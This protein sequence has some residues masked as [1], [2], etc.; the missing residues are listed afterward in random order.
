MLKILELF[1]VHCTYN[2]INK[3]NK[4]QMRNHNNGIKLADAFYYT[5]MYSKQGTTKDNIV[6]TIN[7]KN[8][9]YFSRQAY[10]SKAN[11]IPLEIYL[12]LLTQIRNHYNFNYVDI[13]TPKLI[14]IDGTYNNNVLMEEILNM[15]FYDI[16]NGVP[17]DIKSYGKE[18]KN[19][20]V[21]CAT[22]YIKSN[23]DIFKNN[24]IVADRAYYSYE[25]MDF[26]IKNNI[27][28]II[29]V[30][31]DAPLLTSTK[32]IHKS[33]EHYNE[34]INV[35]NN[36]RVIKYKNIINKTV[37]SGIS[38]KKKNTEYTLEMNNDCVIITNLL[39]ENVYNDE[40]LMD[41]YRQ[42]WSI[43]IFFKYIKS[44]F[45][46]R[47]I[48]EKSKKKIN[49]MYTC[50]LIIM[51][52][53]KIIEETY[54]KTYPIKNKMGYTHN[55]NLTN[56][57]T[58]IHN[59]LLYKLLNNTLTE[60]TLTRFIKCYVKIIIN[61]VDRSF[62]RTSKTPF[63]KWYIKGYSSLSYYAR[64]ISHIINNTTDKLHKNLKTVAKRIISINGK[65]Y[66]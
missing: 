23:T 27:K 9:T 25:F 57:V 53:A 17:I 56:L 37:Y 33:N 65:K 34:I 40:K 54:K 35:K 12:N 45:K 38:K 29:R 60:D 41:M 19:R 48:M 7:N 15:G 36:T 28:F 66:S 46:F 13:D 10:E 58:G 51:F 11:N 6:S 44:N 61:K 18:N 49:K 3:I 20:E 16:T 43:E 14:G 2:S 39:N 63:S 5:F 26:L 59:S 8:N 24:I 31:G 4:V 1:K 52:M 22:N 47:H 62:P 32:K 21:Y 50:E 55:I 30:K 42:R 64:I